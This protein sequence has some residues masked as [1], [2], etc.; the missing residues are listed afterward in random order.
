MGGP[1]PWPTACIAPVACRG[2]RWWTH[3]GAGEAFAAGFLYGYLM[4]GVQRGLDVGGAMGAL[5]CTIEG[6]FALVTLAEVEEVLRSGE[7]EIRR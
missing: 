5:A 3:R 4:D 7:Q 6:H 1:W 2:W